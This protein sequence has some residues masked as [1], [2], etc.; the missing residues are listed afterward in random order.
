MKTGSVFESLVYFFVI[1]L[2][3]CGGLL[4]AEVEAK[5]VN[6]RAVC[7]W[8]W[9]DT[10][11][12]YYQVECDYD[13]AE[14][15]VSFVGYNKDLDQE[16]SMRPEFLSGDG[17]D[18]DKP[19]VLGKEMHAIWDA[20]KD[21]PGYHC[22]DFMVNI[23]VVARRTSETYMIIDLSGGSDAISYPVRYSEVGPDV[24]DDI[25]RTSELWLRRI[26][27]GTFLMGSTD[28]EVGH[29]F[30]GSG[31][32]VTSDLVSGY[33]HGY[34]PETLHSVTLTK[35]FYIGIFECTKTQYA[36]VMGT[37]STSKNPVGIS[38]STVRG[39]S[40]WSTNGHAVGADSFMGR[41]QT[42]TGLTFDLPTEAQWEYACRKRA[43]GS[44]WRTSLNSG[45]NITTTS[46]DP[47]LDEVAYNRPGQTCE[48]VGS[49]LPSELGLYDMHG[50]AFEWCLDWYSS[51]ITSDDV[52]DPVG[53]STGTTRVVRGGGYSCYTNNGVARA[54]YSSTICRAASRLYRDPSKNEYG[55]SSGDGTMGFRVACHFE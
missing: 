20:E 2:S 11:D 16:V 45:K 38:Y 4:H 54:R 21:L 13:D 6:V 52:V 8:P 43:D 10:V 15:T 55:S 23:K 37:P 17:V 50:G 12:I 41:L 7:N 28:G 39:S 49:F 33:S 18:D 25:C 51:K 35:D 14:V 9:K 47:N 34:G 19:V 32:I 36:L 5:V 31:S 48:K 42:R 22:S 30:Y 44:C 27:A 53:E 46:E 26:S 29:R 3:F 40:S 1:F 24:S